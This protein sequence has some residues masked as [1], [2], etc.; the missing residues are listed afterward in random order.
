M[1]KHSIML[2]RSPVHAFR[3]SSPAR[4]PA[5]LAVSGE[6][7]TQRRTREAPSL[8]SQGN[9]RLDWGLSDSFGGNPRT[10]QPTRLP[11]PPASSAQQA[12]NEL[13]CPPRRSYPPRG[14]TGGHAA[15]T[16]GIRGKAR[17]RRPAPINTHGPGPFTARIKHRDP[18]PA[19]RC[20]GR[21]GG[22]TEEETASNT[23]RII[24][25]RHRG[26]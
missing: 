2:I 20:R 13:T 7:A 8:S 25:Q 19:P 15:R 12:N 23:E 17:P 18:C 21:R 26:L 6:F 5:S 22:D 1:H 16:S 11:P 10:W 24:S 3:C 9:S 14:D 4:P